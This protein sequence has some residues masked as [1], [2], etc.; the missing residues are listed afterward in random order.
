M[1]SPTPTAIQGTCAPAF[2]AVRDAFERSFASGDEV[3]AAV[4]IT[5][6]GEVVVDLWAGFRDADQRLPWERETLVNVFS[7]TKGITAIAAH[8]QVEQGRL[9]LDAPVADYWPEFAAAG[10]ERLPV[11]YLLTHQAGRAAIR[12]PLG[13]EVIFD[14]DAMTTALAAEEPWWAPG[15]QHGYHALTFGWLVGELVRRISGQSV[16][17][18]IHEAIA[19]PLGAEFYIGCPEEHDARVAELVPGPIAEPADGAEAFN[20]ADEIRKNP[21]GLFAKAF[22]N[23]R[24]RGLP[25]KMGNDPAW[26]RAEIPA[27]NGHT[28]AHSLARFASICQEN[29]LVP[30]VEPELTLGPGDYDIEEAAHQTE[31]VLSTVFRKLNAYD[32]VPEAMLL[33]PGMVLPGLDAAMVPKEDVAKFTARSMMRTVPPAVPGIHFLSGGMGAEEATSNLQALQRACPNAP[34][35]LSFSFGRALQDSVL[36]TWAGSARAAHVACVCVLAR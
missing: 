36:K 5:R 14:W 29:G 35:S 16:R 22:A 9:D 26:R 18:Y 32:V 34:W 6:G 23:P 2:S 15:S 33:K 10:K 19:T 28:N 1:T 31:R 12:Q 17:D 3:G 7:T 8:Q 25:H 11:R 4:C 20:L 24:P 27:A 13:T 30:I 21:E